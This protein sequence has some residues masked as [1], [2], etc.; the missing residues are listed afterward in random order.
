MDGLLG[1]G[2][3]KVFSDQKY[4]P[5]GVPPVQMLKPFW[6]P[7]ASNET[8]W[9]AALHDYFRESRE[10]FTLAPLADCDIAVLPLD[11]LSVRGSRWPK[12]NDREVLR[13]SVRFA[14]DV[15]SA[16]KRLVIFFSGERSHEPIAI[17]DATVFRQSIYRSRRSVC[18]HA[19]PAFVEDF[20]E[21][22]FDG[23]VPIRKKG[24]M[25]RVGFCG[26]SRPPSL[27]E[28]SRVPLYHASMRM[29]FGRSDVSPY[30]GMALRQRAVELLEAS[31]QI[32]TNFV[33]HRESVFLNGISSIEKKREMRRRFVE[34]MASSDYVLCV[35]GS[36]NF[37][38][39]LY[40]TL[41][42]G[43]IPVFI[44]TD[45]SLPFDTHID[46]KKYCVWIDEADVASLPE[47]LA[48]YHD[49]LSRDD[50]EERQ[51]RCHQLWKE[52]VSPRGFFVRFRDQFE[53]RGNVCV[54]SPA[55][56]AP[57]F[58]SPS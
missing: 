36:S 51:V 38:L 15:Q 28:R 11:W 13:S 14:E 19:F 54:V 31:R 49:D 52:W 5:R 8:G 30:S 56:Q 41:S 1:T 9:R 58:V 29:R 45:C 53:E 43:R 26:L 12:G 42:A 18:D 23:S 34:N 27:L 21:Q 50:F 37:S 25:P 57:R 39:R 46:W 17:R 4:L 2:K 22:Y 35:R 16:G 24:P 48:S 32:T 44:D 33:I 40:E 10:L 47:K 20:V 6:R 7:M 55:S 3:L